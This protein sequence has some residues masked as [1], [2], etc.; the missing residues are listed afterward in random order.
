MKKKRV[1]FLIG[2]ILIVLSI[3]SIFGF[4]YE[5]KEFT[6]DCNKKCTSSSDVKFNV[7]INKFTRNLTISESGKDYFSPYLPLDDNYSQ[8][9]YNKKIKTKEVKL[10]KY[11]Y[12]NVKELYD[13]N[14]KA[15]FNDSTAFMTILLDLVYNDADYCRKDKK[16]IDYFKNI[17]S[18]KDSKTTYRE[19][20]NSMFKDYIKYYR[21]SDETSPNSNRISLS[22]FKCKYDKDSCT[23]TFTLNY[24]EKD[25]NVKVKYYYKENSNIVSFYTDLYVDNKKIDTSK[26]IDYTLI[27]NDNENI[28]EDKPYI[29]RDEL[30]DKLDLQGYIL[31]FDNKNIGF[32]KTIHTS[33]DFS[34]S[35]LDVFKNNNKIAGDIN[36]PGAY[37]ANYMKVNDK[38]LSF[39]YPDCNKKELVELE[40][41]IKGKS[42]STSDKN[43]KKMSEEE[44]LMLE[45][46]DYCYNKDTKEIEKQK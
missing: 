7:K 17:D 16:C 43:T 18:N 2:I 24:D 10:T 15:N 38:S 20:A 12:K 6:F 22:E 1:L 27:K 28:S 3:A 8:D 39:S 23:K 45:E 29:Y 34:S 4:F 42:L 46:N 21:E 5:T 30:K 44:K 32:M 31:I 37:I 26:I 14:K 41:S 19:V 36:L 25:H 35:V 40:F 9:K 33:A 13:L 11:E